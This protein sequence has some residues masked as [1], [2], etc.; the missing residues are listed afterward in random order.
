MLAGIDLGTVE[1]GATLNAC[2]PIVDGS[3]APTDPTVPPSFRVYGSGMGPMPNGQG[4]LQTLDTG[5]LTNATNAAP[6]VVTSAAHNLQ[7]GVKVKVSGVQGNTA[8]NA[9][10]TITKIDA[11]TFSLDGTVGNGAYTAGGSWHVAGLYR[12]SLSINGGDGYAPG[13]TYFVLVS[14]TVAGTSYSMLCVFRVV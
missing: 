9:Q 14:W 4:S 5:N 10:T 12:I 8:A 1:L 6:I 3:N 11:N 13:S 2:V 7:T